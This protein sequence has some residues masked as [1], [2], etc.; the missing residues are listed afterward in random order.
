[1]KAPRYPAIAGHQR[2]ETSEAAAVAIER[3]GRAA[4]LR[5]KCLALLK[6]ESLTADECAERLGE[7][8]LSCRPRLTELGKSGMI[9]DTGLRRPS[10]LG[11][12]SVVWKAK[13]A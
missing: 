13:E 1:M 12:P 5:E 9:V 11:S 8:P 7:D 3:K 2:T 4:N 6:A 10:S